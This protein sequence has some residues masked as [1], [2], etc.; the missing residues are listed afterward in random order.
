[1]AND[2]SGGEPI[3]N[4]TTPV[5]SAEVEIRILNIST[6]RR[7]GGTQCRVHPRADLISQYSQLMA[8]GVHFPP[9]TVWFDGV[10]YWLSDGF[11]RIAA[12]ERTGS[13]TVTAQVK[14]G[15][16]TDAQ[17]DSCNSNS[18]H[19]HRRSVPDLVAAIKR[20]VLHPKANGLSHRQ[21][22][23]H[24]GIPESTFRRLVTHSSAPHG[25]DDSSVAART[26][27]RNGTHYQMNTAGINRHRQ[28]HSET[29]KTSSLSDLKQG[30]VRMRLS[31]S[32]E[33]HR[34]LTVIG[35]WA[36]GPVAPDNC[37]QALERILDDVKHLNAQH[38]NGPSRARASTV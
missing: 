23:H 4:P 26:V 12:L 17:W 7:D 25:A 3:S 31:A 21:L 6:I 10:D 34:I 15:T 35:N 36:F 1:M 29:S 24:V 11:Q 14:Q 16:L 20:A 18:T 33:A 2:R 37:L 32:P 8:E 38:I 19:G 5:R 22:A 9:V 30:L 28:S 13:Q 27:Y